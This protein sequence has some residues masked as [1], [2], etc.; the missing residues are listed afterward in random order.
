VFGG[1][2]IKILRAFS[3]YYRLYTTC[4]LAGV[5]FDVDQSTVWGDIR[6]LK[7]LVKEHTHIPEKMEDKMGKIGGIDELLKLFPD[8]GAFV[9][10]ALEE[11]PDQRINR[12]EKISTLVKRKCM[13]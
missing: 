7:P 6:H 11:I 5:I 1:S 13:L 9:D 12:K 2:K 8:L 10:T 4:A 3:V